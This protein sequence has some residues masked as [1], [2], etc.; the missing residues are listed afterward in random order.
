VDSAGEGVSFNAKEWSQSFLEKA[1]LNTLTPTLEVADGKI[2]SFSIAQSA[3]EAHPTLRSHFVEVGVFDMEEGKAVFRTSYKINVLPQEVTEVEVLKGEPAP[4]MTFINMND[5]G[6][7]KVLC[8]PISMEF[9]KEHLG[10]LDS[11]LL[12]QQ[13]WAVFYNMTRDALMSADDFLDLVLKHVCTED[14]PKLV[15]TIIRRANAACSAFIPDAM[16]EEYSDSLFKVAFKKLEDSTEAQ[17]QIV[18]QRAAIGFARSKASVEIL[19]KYLGEGEKIGTF[20]LDQSS[21]WSVVQKAM[22]HN[23]DG[24][25]ELLAKESEKDGSDRGLRSALTAKSSKWDEKVKA[26]AWAR[27]MSKDTKA[28]HH[29]QSADFAGFR[30][31]HQREMLEKYKQLFFDNIKDVYKDRT[32]EF[33]RSFFYNLFPHCPEDPEVFEKTE[34]LLASLDEKDAIL[35]RIVKEQLDDLNRA[36]KCRALIFAK[37]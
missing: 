28:S 4:A 14:S 18:W 7:I 15:Q 5:H 33:S 8:D 13:L 34:A 31:F 25:E 24:A 37:L 35:R 17:W 21:R 26:E 11:S 10:K 27:Y 19:A 29:E 6:Y 16:R 12:R 23:I 32:K 20:E 1:G 36:K 30:W 2:T 3:P 22:A 9:A